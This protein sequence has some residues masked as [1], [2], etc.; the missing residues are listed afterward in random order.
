MRNEELFEVRI[1]P[2]GHSS[3]SCAKIRRLSEGS[4]AL[5]LPVIANDREVSAFF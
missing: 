4:E 3:S 1:T 2:G 5:T